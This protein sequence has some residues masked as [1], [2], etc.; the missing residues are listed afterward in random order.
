M[1]VPGRIPRVVPSTGAVFCEKVIPPGTIV[2]HSAYVYHFHDAYFNDP[3]TFKPERWMEANSSD[4]DK[5]LVS[6]SRGTRG[7]L[8]LK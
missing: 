6:F 1:G 3:F 8:G 2:S 4:L 7:C 5:Y